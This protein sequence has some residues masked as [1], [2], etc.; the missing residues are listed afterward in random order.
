MKKI[1]FLIILFLLFSKTQSEVIFENSTIKIKGFFY[2]SD[3]SLLIQIENKTDSIILINGK[4]PQYITIN[5]ILL[6]Y[7][8]IMPTDDIYKPQSASWGE[9]VNLK[10]VM[11]KA[12]YSILINKDLLDKNLLNIHDIEIWIEFQYVT[13]PKKTIIYSPIYPLDFKQDISMLGL[14]LNKYR[15]S[16]K[17]N[18]LENNTCLK[19][20]TL[21]SAYHSIYHYPFKPEGKISFWQKIIGKSTIKYHRI[22]PPAG[23]DFLYNE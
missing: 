12:T 10:R 11:P 7:I 5:G 18:D 6:A 13:H 19:H 9:K 14:N 22:S 21:K 23:I 20:L 3:S 16:M 15:I 4:D 8:E 1:K 2:L 17:I